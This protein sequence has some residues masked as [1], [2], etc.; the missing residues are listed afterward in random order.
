MTPA[1]PDSTEP[2]TYAE[3]LRGRRFW[4]PLIACLAALTIGG[5][6]W[7]SS[8]APVP[9]PAPRQSLTRL[10][11]VVASLIQRLQA[12]RIF[13]GALQPAG[14][15]G[16]SCL[17]GTASTRT[18]IQ[19]FSTHRAVVAQI[20]VLERAA[21]GAFAKGK[22]VEYLISGPLWLLSGTW[23]TTGAYAANQTGDAL[24]AQQV[25]TAL[26]GCLELVPREAGS[27]AF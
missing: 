18:S 9:K 3:R 22:V 1:E 23:S 19:A 6:V 16:A 14:P 13:C 11:P 10:D 21:K 5:F 27:C 26:S 8:L 17:F 20:A 12:R 4:L 7:Q 15:H 25:S 2:T 24:A